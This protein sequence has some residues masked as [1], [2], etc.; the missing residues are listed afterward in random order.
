VDIKFLKWMLKFHKLWFSVGA[1]GCKQKL[2]AVKNIN[3]KKYIFFLFEFQLN[4]IE[5]N[6]LQ[7]R[8]WWDEN[9]IGK[10][11]SNKKRTLGINGNAQNWSLN[12][13]SR[14]TLSRASVW[15]DRAE[16]LGF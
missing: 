16:N 3:F 12:F 4:K 8:W 14:W 6:S 15:I 10:G 13:I 11:M 5:H 1:C 2:F 7:S 9:A